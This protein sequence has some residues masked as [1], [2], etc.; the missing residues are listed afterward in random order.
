[1]QIFDENNKLIN[2]ETVENIEQE[3]AKKYIKE[4]DK[5]LE[6]GARYGS[7]SII[8]NKIIKDKNSHYVVEPDKLVWDILYKNMINNNCSF[9]IIKGIIGNKK[10]KLVGNGYEKTSIEDDK[11]DIELFKIP[12]VDFN[13]LIVDCEGYLEIFYNENKNF[14]NKLNKIILE[15]D[16]PDICNY[17]YVLNELK[18]KNFKT[19][20]YIIHYGLKYLVLIKS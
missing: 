2:I 15:C 6:L 9:N 1:M 7:V 5:V 11:G 10:Y 3:L 12:N 16:R 8:T 18:N 4:N 19:V 14:F 17:D 13:T 20:D